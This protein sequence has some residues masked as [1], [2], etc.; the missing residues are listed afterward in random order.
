MNLEDFAQGFRVP[1][2]RFATE[3][4]EQRGRRRDGVRLM[5]SDSRTDRHQGF[6]ELPQ[7]LERGDLLVV[8]ASAM[9]AASLPAKGRVGRFR[10]NLSSEYAPDLWLA[11]P[12]WDFDRPGPLPLRP[13]ERFEVGR[14]TGR[15]VGEFPGTRRLAFVR[16]DE[17]V[18]DLLA[19]HGEPIRYG[20]HRHPLPLASYR[21]LFSRVPGSVE[22]P[23]AGRPFTP[24][25][26]RELEAAGVRRA[27]VVLHAGVSS[28]DMAGGDRLRALV[29]PEP[30]CVPVETVRA[31]EA[32]H[33]A[34]HRVVAVGTTVA[35]AIESARTAGGLRA[36]RGFTGLFLT[37]QNPA[38]VVDG[39]LT[40]L[41]DPGTTH[42]ALLGAVAGERT[43][44]RAYRAALREGYAWHEF[45]D[46]H[47]LWRG[48]RAAG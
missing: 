42:I 20:Y 5:V 37:P 47:L 1:P 21:T 45:G 24:A 43:V 6:P 31:V 35:R 9:I 41:H 14:G 16:F 3:P 40:G 34:G 10:L 19:E 29:Y 12:R 27:E 39:L 30:F 36:V 17:S 8:N 28:L 33:R 4:P 32:T 26:V 2:D 25:T 7:L 11:E 44:L 48:P 15:V 23:S 46:L 18:A 22:M 13:G 38:T